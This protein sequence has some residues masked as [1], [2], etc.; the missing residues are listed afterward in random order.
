MGCWLRNQR[1]G[2]SPFRAVADVVSWFGAMQYQDYGGAEWGVGLRCPGATG[3]T[4]DQAFN[5][6]A[7][8]RKHLRPDLGGSAVPPALLF[9]LRD[10]PPQSES[11]DHWRSWA[12]LLAATKSHG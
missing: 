10:L 12:T 4:I 1:F 2:T 9:L 11:G 8:L 3:A 6:D 5:D 7:I